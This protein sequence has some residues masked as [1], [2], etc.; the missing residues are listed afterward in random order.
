MQRLRTFVAVMALFA[1]LGLTGNV[2]AA[3]RD[4]DGPRVRDAETQKQQKGK[5]KGWIAKIVKILDEL[6]SKVSIPPG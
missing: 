3:R 4:S 6:E 1:T 5:P 2:F